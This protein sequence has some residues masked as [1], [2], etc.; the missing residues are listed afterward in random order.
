MAS[1]QIV[2]M[3]PPDLEFAAAYTAAEGWL[4][5]IRQVFEGFRAHDPE[6]CFVARTNGR[7]RLE[8]L[9]SA[10]VC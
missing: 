10:S 2:A 6:G 1:I 9:R 7:R 5:Q 3:Q 4:T 8:A